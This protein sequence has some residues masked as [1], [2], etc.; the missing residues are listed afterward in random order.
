[1]RD[2]NTRVDHLKQL[3]LENQLEK[4]NIEMQVEFLIKQTNER[5]KQMNGLKNLI[6]QQKFWSKS[7]IQYVKQQLIICW[8][9]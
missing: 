8:T 1:M 9:K 7:K 3:L 2:K 5:I 6:I 4:D